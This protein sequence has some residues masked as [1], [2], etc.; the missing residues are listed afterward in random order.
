MFHA[1][2]SSFAGAVIFPWQEDVILPFL[3]GNCKGCSYH[4][5]MVLC[6]LLPSRKTEANCEVS[7][8]AK[9]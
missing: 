2:A 8:S 7:A 3:R 6:V 4:V 9:K 1:E 5:L